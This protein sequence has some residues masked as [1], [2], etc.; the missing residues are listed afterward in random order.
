MTINTCSPKNSHRYTKST[1]KSSDLPR[2]AA[3]SN[4]EESCVGVGVILSGT[5]IH[6]VIMVENVRIQPS[7]HSFAWN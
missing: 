4:G 6:P 7:V 3:R 2:R 1:E 5:R